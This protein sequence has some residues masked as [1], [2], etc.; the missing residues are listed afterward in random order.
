L[1]RQRINDAARAN[2]IT[3]A[4]E[5]DL[6][7]IGAFAGVD[8]LAG[9][10]ESRYRARV[11]QGFARLAAAGPSGS[12]RAYVMGLSLEI[13][14]VGI[15][16]PTP[17][18]VVI[19]LL[20]FEDV[21]QATT[22]EIARGH[23]LFEQAQAAKLGVERILCRP[24]ADII[25]RTRDLLNKQDIRPLTD[26]ISVRPA[27]ILEFEIKAKLV[28]YP[29]PDVTLVIADAK[30]QLKAYLRSIRKV[31]YDA[32]RS[33]IIA[34]LNTGGVQNVILTKPEGDVV[35]GFYDVSCAL[36]IDVELS[37]VDI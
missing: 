16:S 32:T 23:A 2:T 31:G 12:Y 30:E 13:I 18:E 10:D 25:A 4:K 7:V 14:D 11:Q 36:K 1:L 37:H 19:T 17:G 35:C 21:T 15:H 26:Q 27:N 34:A 8:P 22:Q 24:D 9:E 6:E 5:Q 3:L 29:G 20:A 33:G 28:I